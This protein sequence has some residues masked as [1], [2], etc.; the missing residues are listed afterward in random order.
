[1]IKFWQLDEFR[2]FV[3]YIYAEAYTREGGTVNPRNRLEISTEIPSALLSVALAWKAP[4]AACGKPIHVFRA[5][6][7]PSKRGTPLSNIY[8]AVACPLD[9]SIG[10]SRGGDAREAYIAIAKM[11]P[12]KPQNQEQPALFGASGGQGETG[13]K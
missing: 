12:K 6:R 5:R 2:R 4:C 13:E 1:M 11:L 7:S 10:C 3:P 8:L 9:Q